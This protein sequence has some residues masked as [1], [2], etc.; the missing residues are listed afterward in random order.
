MKR[1]VF[2]S[3]IAAIAFVASYGTLQAGPIAPLPAT[4]TN[5][6]NVIHAHYWHGRYYP[7]YWH[8]HY[9]GHRGW[10]HHHWYYW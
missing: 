7:Y 4:V 3:A 9:Y 5:A 2:A 1:L 6:N 10:R 8:H